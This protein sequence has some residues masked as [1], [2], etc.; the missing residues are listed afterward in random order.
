MS[1][2]KIIY[3]NEASDC[4]IIQIS[5]RRIQIVFF[6]M[7]I[8]LL[9]LILR[10]FDLSIFN[11]SDLQSI[12]QNKNEINI[13][14]NIVDRNGIILASTL[15]TASAY[16]YPKHFT[17]S[18]Q[19]LKSIS[20]IIEHRPYFFLN[21]NINYNS[22]EQII[23]PEGCLSVPMEHVIKKYNG[24]VDVKRPID[25]QLN[26]IDEYLKKKE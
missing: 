22:D 24:I 17:N 25:I 18:I 12:T 20:R 16:I 5:H 1:S 6:S 7:F 19:S 8:V 21:P 13:R 26:Y 9:T 10:I 3:T 15:P 2:I 4:E 11:Y 23:L 14:N